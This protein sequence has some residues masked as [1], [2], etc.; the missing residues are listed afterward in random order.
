MRQK[1][2]SGKL[3]EEMEKEEAGSGLYLNTRTH[4]AD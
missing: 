1:V 3:K 2:K 4:P